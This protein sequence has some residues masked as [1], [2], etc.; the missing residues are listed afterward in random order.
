VG[1]S[2][3][4]Q[5]LV[6]HALNHDHDLVIYVAPTRAIINEIEVV[7]HLPPESV[8]ILR[9]RPRS[10]CGEVDAAWKDLER[11]GCAAFARATLCKPCVQR[12]VNGGNC[13]WPDQLD[14]VGKD[15]RL[16]VLTEQYLLLN[17][18]L[19]RQIRQKVK[20]QRQ[21]VILDEA[22]FTTTAVVRRFTK[23]DL[24]HFRDALFEAEKTSGAAGA[25]IKAWLEG[26]DFLLDH[27][28]E[29][30]TLRR[31]WSNRLQFGVLATQL[32][33][34][35]TFGSTFRYLAP[36]LEL[37]NSAVTTGQWRDGDTFEIV[38]RV[39]TMGSDVMIMA[40]YLDT[41]IVE[42]RLS[43][44]AI[45]LFSNVGFRHSETRILNI[46]D[47]IGTARTLSHPDHF[48]RVVNFFVALILRNVDQGRRTVLV[49]RKQ[50]LCRVKARVE[51]ISVTL[52]RPL[53]CVMASTDKP[54]DTCVP[55]EIALI[56]YGVVGINS[57]QSFDHVYCVGGY[58]ARADHLNAVYQ[59]TLPPDSRMPIGVRME[60]RRRQVYAADGEFN[61][62]F[63]AK[64]AAVT[65]RMIERRVVLQA[66]GRVRP[67]TTP[68]EVIL[69]QCDDLSAELGPIEE[70]G[71]LAAA[72]RTLHVPTLSQ[73]KRAAL[74]EN[75]RVRQKSGESLRTIAADLGISLS[76]ASW[77]ARKEGLDQLLGGS[78]HDGA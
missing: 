69:F 37:L 45:E 51:D 5:V 2:Q 48:N 25:G 35:Q 40:P 17:P 71:S 22:L 32:A 70:F 33:G 14:K 68:A 28:V 52:G 49:T 43:R 23:T 1:K 16:V 11:N 53:T 66:I 67:F 65:H 47:P 18:L 59:Q 19:I 26:I 9:P 63:H 55:T 34:H 38:V 46:T 36:E 56:N 30:E 13:S 10:L 73:L 39:D 31:F 44:P 60:G 12:D 21:L 4:A 57:L 29:L 61:T 58:Y 64:R 50:F 77:T 20:A 75:I 6:H 78:D 76:T 74:G 54:F 72:R 24:E 62:R 15:T 42:E 3:A 27:D 8:V 41:E 7:P